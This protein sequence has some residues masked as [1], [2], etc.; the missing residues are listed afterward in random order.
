MAESKGRL[1]IC[2]KPLGTPREPNAASIRRAPISFRVSGFGFRV[3]ALRF[4]VWGLGVSENMGYLLGVL[5]IREFYYLGVVLGSL[6]FATP[7]PHID[8]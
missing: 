5:L 1:R 6:T 8:F 3:S 7:P 4:R 2:S